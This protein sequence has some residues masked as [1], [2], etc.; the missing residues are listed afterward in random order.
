LAADE[1]AILEDLLHSRDVIDDVL[2]VIREV[3]V[4]QSAMGRKKH[5][6]S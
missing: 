6:E 5:V 3:R 4:T 2:L 1:R